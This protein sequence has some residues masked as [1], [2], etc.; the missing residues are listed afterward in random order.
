MSWFKW[1]KKPIVLGFWTANNPDDL[2]LFRPLGIGCLK[3]SIDRYLPYPATC[4]VI[5]GPQDDRLKQVDILLLS[6]LSQDFGEIPGMVRRYRELVPDG[7]VVLGGQHISQFPTL[8]PEGVDVGCLGEG[9]YA[10]LHIIKALKT[11]AGHL[12]SAMG[13]VPGVVYRPSENSMELVV[14]PPERLQRLEDLPLPDRTFDGGEV[15][16]PYLLT[17]R[18]C[19]FHCT[20]C[21]SSVFWNKVR[22]LPAKYVLADLKKL[23]REFPRAGAVCICD[24]LFVGNVPRLYEIRTLMEQ[25]GIKGNLHLACNVRAE[26]V[27]DELCALMKDIG[28][29]ACSFGFESG[30][31]KILK[32]LKPDGKVSVKQNIQA[33]EMLHSRGFLVNASCV[34]GVPG[35]TEDEVRQTYEMVLEQ[36]RLNRVSAAVFNILMPMPGTYYWDYAVTKGLINLDGGSFHWNQLRY[37]ADPA[38][39]HCK[40]FR[41]WADKRVRNRSIYLNEDD[42]PH[43]RLLALMEEYHR[44]YRSIMESRSQAS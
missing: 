37:Y 9:E 42:L 7:R 24:D 40:H 8:L 15:L 2:D 44:E 11:S 30:V 1:M 13:G 39:S 31:D 10:V 16:S 18:G 5:R 21:S 25:E 3:A 20:F 35:E 38:V 32:K 36:A 12:A 19:P 14:Q 29:G 4:Y 28:I 41:E 6:S 33:I 34:I 26:L 17:S 23:L 22:Y 27:N 43:E